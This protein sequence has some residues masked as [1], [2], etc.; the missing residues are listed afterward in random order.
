MNLRVML[1]FAIAI[2]LACTTA[3][4][5]SYSQDS[6]PPDSSNNPTAPAKELDFGPFMADLQRKIKRNWYPPIRQESR[7]IVASFRIHKDG[8]ITNLKIKTPSGIARV[9]DAGLSAV[10]S[11]SPMRP[12]PDGAPESVDIQFTF[13][14]NVLANTDAL[15]RTIAELEKNPDENADKLT[16]NLLSKATRY[17]MQHDYEKSEETYKHAAAIVQKAHGSKS[18]E[19]SSLLESEARDLYCTKEDYVRA[20]ATLD[21]AIGILDQDSHPIEIARCEKSMATLV[22]EPQNHWK[23]AEQLL[24]SAIA[25]AKLAKTIAPQLLAVGELANCYIAEDKKPQAI[26]VLSEA[27]EAVQ[28]DKIDDKES[29]NELTGLMYLLNRFDSRK[30]TQL[31][32]SYLQKYKESGTSDQYQKLLQVCVLL[33][34]KSKDPEFFAKYGAKYESAPPS[35]TPTAGSGA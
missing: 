6:R 4:S 15:D 2:V 1:L 26:S 29:I 14:Y 33:S 24:I 18:V 19:M 30:A 16:K 7:R 25:H 20:K 22:E 5:V 10:Q 9:D 13:D 31:A 28:K 21:K 23:N 17:A 35:P 32:E 12:L 11:A 34:D 8:I 27:I 3:S